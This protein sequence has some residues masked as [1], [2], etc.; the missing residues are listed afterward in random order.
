MQHHAHTHQRQERGRVA[1]DTVVNQLEGKKEGSR[2]VKGW[3]MTSTL[4]VCCRILKPFKM[5]PC[6]LI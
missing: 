5:K 2:L 6:W 3:H 4:D 1:E